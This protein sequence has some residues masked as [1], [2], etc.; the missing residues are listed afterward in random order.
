MHQEHRGRSALITFA[1]CLFRFAGRTA[2]AFI[3]A[4][5]SIIAPAHADDRM[6][7][8]KTTAK[9][10]PAAPYRPAGED[11]VRKIIDRA[12]P[13]EKDNIAVLMPLTGAWDCT[14]VM[15][16]DL[17]STPEQTTATVTNEMTLGDR[18]LSSKAT[19][20]LIIGG[21]TMPWEEQG[22]IGFDN[23]KK[24]FTSIWVDTTTTGMMTGQGKFDE[25]QRTLTQTGRFT[26]PLNGAEE[27]FRSELRFTDADSYK[28]TIFAAGK[29]GK[30]SKLMDIDCSRRK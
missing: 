4:W 7:G 6:A 18:F 10:A 1:Q 14:V 15:H 19:G 20:S 27:T 22:L 9:K 24:S 3:L 13:S 28:R 12:T 16:T 21:Q 23:A 29:A 17:S 8:E 11:T 5:M 30:E 25:K 2:P 26:N